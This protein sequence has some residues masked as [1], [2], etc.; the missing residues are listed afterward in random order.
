MLL[1]TS[2]GSYSATI[3]LM[4][5][6]EESFSLSEIGLIGS[7]EIVTVNRSQL[8]NDTVVFPMFSSIRKTAAQRSL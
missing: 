5:R 4:D 8:N 7:I 1:I 3:P 6:A 2:K